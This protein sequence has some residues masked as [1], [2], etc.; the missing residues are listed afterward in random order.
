LYESGEAPAVGP[1]YKGKRG[2]QL[3]QQGVPTKYGQKVGRVHLFAG[4]QVPKCGGASPH[5]AGEG[6]R[7]VGQVIIV[8][9]T[10]IGPVH[11]VGAPLVECSRCWVP[12]GAILTV[13]GTASG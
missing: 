2:S 8:G 3:A 1:V 9:V 4:G 7:L 10:G 11:L 6:G 13:L 5:Q 12:I